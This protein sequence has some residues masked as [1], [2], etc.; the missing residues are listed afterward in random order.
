MN[1]YCRRAVAQGV[2]LARDTGGT[3][4]VVTLGPPSAEDVLREA[5]AWGADAGLHA[6]DPAFAGSDTLATARALAAVLRAA[7]PFDLVL[8]GPQLHRRRD[9]AGRPG[10]GRAARPPLRRRG[11][12]AGG[13]GTGLAP[14]ARAR[15]RHPGG[16]DGAAGGA[17]GG[18][19]PVRP[20]Q[21][22]P[23]GPGRRG[24]GAADPAGR[25]PARPRALG[26][27]GQPDGRRGDAPHGARRAPS[28]SSTAPSTRRSTR[29]CACSTARGALTARPDAGG[30][31]R[32]RRRPG[33]GD[34]GASRVIAVLAEPGRQRVDRGA[35]RRGGAP[36]GRRWTPPS[37]R[38][39]PR[40]RPVERATPPAG[41]GRGRLVVARA[42]RLGPSPRTWPTRSPPTSGRRRRG[43]CSPRAPRSAARWPAVPP[44]PRARDWWATPSRSSARDDVLVAAKPAFAGALVADITCRSATQM[45]TVRPGV[46]P[47][48]RPR[49]R[50]V[51]CPS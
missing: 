24:A 35:P 42:A 41:R 27:G 10:A 9:G 33:R 45:V 20:L 49:G 13:R 25:R 17:V 19:A 12:P 15:R 2:T 44:P 39:R 5:V 23:G 14:R 43:R 4:T 28:A 8:L 31:R 22:R 38:C 1:P 21:G 30:E 29:P 46:L 6:C 51:P 37:T 47:A 48:A 32:R 11:A 7:G 40:R 50:S 16:G 3:C 18:R 26:R 34:R 36:G